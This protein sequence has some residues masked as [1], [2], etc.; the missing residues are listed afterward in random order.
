LHP[1][2]V[3]EIYDERLNEGIKFIAVVGDLNDTPDSRPLT[4]LLNNWSTLVDIMEHNKFK[5]DGHPGT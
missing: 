4:R 1:K 2:K 5:K 3:R